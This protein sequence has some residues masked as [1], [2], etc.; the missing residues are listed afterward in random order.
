[1]TTTDVTA[2]Q[3]VTT[4]DTDAN[5]I[6]AIMRGVKQNRKSL[7]DV[8]VIGKL[9]KWDIHKILDVCYNNYVFYFTVLKTY[10][11]F[12][13]AFQIHSLIAYSLMNKMS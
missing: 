3:N 6:T 8:P 12:L 1:M 13:N 11:L 4:P 10:L 9:F 2:G 7:D 5:T